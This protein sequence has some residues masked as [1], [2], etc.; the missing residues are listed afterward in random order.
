MAFQ[1]AQLV[2]KFLENTSS[3]EPVI[4]TVPH[5]YAP[6][7]QTT[8]DVGPKLANLKTPTEIYDKVETPPVQTRPSSVTGAV[9]K[10][11]SFL[12]DLFNPKT[13]YDYYADKAGKLVNTTTPLKVGRTYRFV[14]TPVGSNAK[15]LACKG[16]TITFAGHGISCLDTGIWKGTKDVYLICRIA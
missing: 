12:G 3:T 6:V 15:I 7:L 1:T 14:V 11:L 13:A 9:G 4:E 8:A 2:A 10:G 16:K 5:N